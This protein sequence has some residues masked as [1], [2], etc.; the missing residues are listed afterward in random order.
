MVFE[1][2]KELCEKKG[3]SITQLEKEAKLSPGS[4]NKWKKSSP[5]AKSIQAV[6]KV[7]KVK[8]ETLL[9]E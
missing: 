1:N 3:I 5:T 2:V 6:A 4:I 7:L 9:K 8:I